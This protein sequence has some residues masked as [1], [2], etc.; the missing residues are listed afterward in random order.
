MAPAGINSLTRIAD[1]GSAVSSAIRSETYVVI[2]FFGSYAAELS[3]LTTSS[4]LLE[5]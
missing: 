3:S 1:F 4:G 2:A 5:L